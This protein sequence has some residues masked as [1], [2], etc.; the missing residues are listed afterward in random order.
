MRYPPTR[1]YMDVRNCYRL[2]LVHILG[3]FPLVGNCIEL[4]YR[5]VVRMCISMVT[6]YSKIKDQPGKVA[7]PARVQLIR[8]NGYFPVPVRAREF[9][10]ARQV[11]PSR[12]ASAC[13]LSTP[14]LNLIGRCLLTGFLPLSAAAS[15][16]LYRQLPSDQFRV[17]QV[18]QLRT[19]GVHCRKS[20]GTGPA[21]LKAV[22]VSGAAFSG[23]IMHQFLYAFLLPHSLLYSYVVYMCHTQS[24]L[25]R[26]KVFGVPC[27]TLY[28]TRPRKWSFR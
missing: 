28:S 4:Q 23:I 24:I 10:L 2:F 25:R 22:P 18:T 6:T 5:Y 17:Y 27:S 26:E 8:E 7:N 11:R 19:D 9:G 13:S 14:R 1:L 12:L 21:V 20:V 16:Y 3:P 15:I